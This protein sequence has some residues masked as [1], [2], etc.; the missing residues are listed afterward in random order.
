MKTLKALGASALWTMVVLSSCGKPSPETQA[1]GVSSITVSPT[2]LALS[3][4]ETA[5]ISPAVSPPDATNPT[6][7]WSS[8]D[9]VV[10]TVSAGIVTAMAPGEATITATADGKSATCQVT[11]SLKAMSVTEALNASD[12]RVR[13]TGAIVAAKSLRSVIITDGTCNMEVENTN[14]IPC[15]V[16][17]KVD[18]EAEKYFVSGFNKLK[19]ATLEIVSSGNDVPHTELKDIS[20]TIDE[21]TAS[22]S[23]Y[24]TVTFTYEGDYEGCLAGTI[25]PSTR[26]ICVDALTFPDNLKDGDVIVITGYVSNP[27]KEALYIVANGI[28]IKLASPQAVDLGLS[29]LWADRNVGAS[30]AED[31][32]DYFAW[33]ETAPKDLYDWS[34]YRWAK[35]S[36]SALTKYNTRS[37]FG[38]V[39]NPPLTRLESV[40][41]AACFATGG[42]WRMP[43]KE[44]LEE[45]MNNCKWEMTT[46]ETQTHGI[47]SGARV[48][49]LT[50]GKSIFIP[51]AGCIEG[52]RRVK[53]NEYGLYS[54]A[55]ICTADNN[56]HGYRDFFILYLFFDNR[57]KEIY[58]DSRARGWTIRPVKDKP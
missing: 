56:S 18:A 40:D 33:G 16:G 15:A 12:G 43:T 10:A 54:S 55:D 31:C 32:G 3:V 4:G 7:S 2:S 45:L 23:E 47:V 21:Y 41:D 9:N 34:N 22:Q 28:Q 50:T 39:D 17:D 53:R 36:P 46:L 20:S 6:V 49:S 30:A 29:V 58:G 44:E 24:L 5:T 38:D 14:D 37:E 13:I 52:S 48:V 11:V 19:N 57:L 51:A 1:T 42:E 26:K 27:G 35:G 25:P 8:S